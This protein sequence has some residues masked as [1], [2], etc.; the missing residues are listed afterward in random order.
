MEV[1]PAP[2]RNNPDPGDP[3]PSPGAAGTGDGHVEVVGAT[4]IDGSEQ[5]QDQD[6]QDQGELDE[7]LAAPASSLHWISCTEPPL[8]CPPAGWPTLLKV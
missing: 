7:G 2:A 8:A 1:L 4:Q 5:H 3:D 6:R